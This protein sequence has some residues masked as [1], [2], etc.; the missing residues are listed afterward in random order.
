MGTELSLAAQQWIN[1]VLVWIGLS[2]VAGL[3]ARALLPI[4]RRMGA[5]ATLLIGASGSATGLSVLS[6]LV[7]DAGMLSPVGPLGVFVSIVGACAVLLV[8]N[9]L[10]SA[11][12]R[13]PE[14]EVE[15]DSA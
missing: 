8:F 15:V 5:S 12:H 7:T 3:A 6:M 11:V 1:A 2:M 9:M 10:C 14:A 4:R 13:E